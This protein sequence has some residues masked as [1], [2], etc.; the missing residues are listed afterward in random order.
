MLR[1][2]LLVLTSLLIWTSNGETAPYRRSSIVKAEYQNQPIEAPTPRAEFRIAHDPWIGQDKILDHFAVAF[3]LAAVTDRVTNAKSG[4][5]EGRVLLWSA[6]FWTANEVKD[7]VAPWEKVG[8]IGGEGFSYKDLL[9]S[10]A[11][12]GLALTVF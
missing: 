7:A 10:L 2:A 12:V 5:A 8:W 6:G 11:G 3:V 4:A 1:N 9:W